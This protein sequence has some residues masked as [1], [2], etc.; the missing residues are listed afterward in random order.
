MS[1]ENVA[2]TPALRPLTP[3]DVLAFKE[4]DDVQISPD[5]A[6][7]AF[8]V[9]DAF[10]TDTKSA[11]SQIWVVPVEPGPRT[12]DESR[13]HDEGGEAR[14]FTTGPHADN[15]PRWSPD[16][17]KLAFLSDRLEDGKP[18]IYLLDR[19][20]GEARKLADLP[21]S[22][23]DLAWSPDGTTL[24]FLMEDPEPE[25]EKR[26]KQN[27]DDAIE[28]EKRHNWQRLWTVDVA[29]GATRQI[30]G[31]V[32]VW[33][34][35]WAPDG[36]FALLVAA[37]PYEWSW[38]IARLARVGPEGGMPETTYTVPEKQ[39]GCPR[40][41]PDGAQLAFL[42]CI[43]SDR[44]T[45][46]GDVF[47]MPAVGGE[48]RNLT[49][50][51]GGS[52]GWIEWSPDGGALDYIGYEDGEAVIGRIDVATGA[53]VTHWKGSCAIKGSYGG[54]YLARSTGALAISREDPTHPTEIWLARPTTDDRREGAI[55]RAPTYPPPTNDTKDA[56]QSVVGLEWRQLTRIQP[57]ADDLA[58]GE[59]HVVRWRSDDGLEIQGL[60]LLPAS[61]REG[62]RIP[63]ITWIHGGPASLYTL[64]FN[65][66]GRGL[67]L[68]ASA[69]YAAL[70][71][72]PRGSTGWGVPFTE[73]NI[74]DFGG[75]DF[76]DIMSGVDHVIALGI[77]DP[78][79]L[80]VGG[81]SYGGFIT[82]WA[83]TQTERF[84]A[85]IAGAPITHW[86]SFHG[87]AEIGTWDQ[88]AYRA[89]PYEQGGR[90]DR[91]SPIHYVDQA[92]TPTLLIHGQD[93][94]I[95]PV[96]QSYEFFRALK[97]HG[98]PTELVV[99]P[100]ESHGPRERAHQL[101]RLRRYLEWFQRY[102]G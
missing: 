37:E 24:G 3:E 94:T 11:K 67:Q 75:H 7:I 85:A 76:E 14:P 96:G 82:A 101:D 25:G 89:S 31:D 27:K 52:I 83:V 100:R 12:P 4:L 34:F 80:G 51:Y 81:W 63:M 20:G 23:A 62:Q 86:R 18:Q 58:L 33:E 43:W 93:D 70:L 98:V 45:N 65:G 5:G 84:K 90:Y 49:E 6:L 9:G 69:G 28:V 73:A 47:V 44:S 32:Q 36:G 41:S 10:K 64:G 71:P 54:C 1:T 66:A 74:G 22:P 61:Y 35:D 91:F 77:A 2:M 88:I 97:D 92:K 50:G 38:F 95:V 87:V 15:T 19:A 57:P 60:L 48:A 13:G 72:N 55:Y 68:F 8:V 56:Q 39:F 40:V 59:T 17:T 79:R 46:E 102:I 30:T 21:S 16:G 99:Y 26:R 53:R 42:S 78:A 29:S